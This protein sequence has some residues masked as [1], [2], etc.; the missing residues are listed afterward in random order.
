MSERPVKPLEPCARCGSYPV[1]CGARSYPRYRCTGWVEVEGRRT[2]CPREG[3]GF[4]VMKLGL[5]F[6]RGRA[7]AAWN[8]QQRAGQGRREG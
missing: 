6:A 3:E 5:S 7:K 2:P 4:N 1:L 8:K